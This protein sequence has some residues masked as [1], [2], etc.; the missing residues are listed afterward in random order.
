MI[1]E[2][3]FK[4]ILAV[5]G[6]VFYVIKMGG[7][8]AT[9][10]DVVTLHSKRKDMITENRSI[11]CKYSRILIVV[12]SFMVGFLSYRFVIDD[13]LDEFSLKVYVI[14]SI[15]E[16]YIFYRIVYFAICFIATTLAEYDSNKE[17]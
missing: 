9:G 3:L 5:L 7:A 12:S 14:L 6:M 16:W 13:M 15:L 1:S 17:R 4:T 2:T 10:L 11:Y 8:F